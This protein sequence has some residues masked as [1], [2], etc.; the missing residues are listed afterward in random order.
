[1]KNS[2]EIVSFK[3]E[4]CENSLELNGC[5]L[6]RRGKVIHSIHFDPLSVVDLFLAFTIWG[7][8]CQGISWASFQTCY[9]FSDNG[10]KEKWKKVSVPWMAL[11]VRE[12]KYES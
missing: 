8:F 5:A 3:F 1:M 12:S 9:L 7:S 11:I 2:K 6:M 10:K 4:T